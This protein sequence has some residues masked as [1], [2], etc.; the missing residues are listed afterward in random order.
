VRIK[1]RNHGE[2]RVKTATKKD[3]KFTKEWEGCKRIGEKGESYDKMDIN[4][5]LTC[6]YSSGE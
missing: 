3:A 6:R 2:C 4:R 5:A 1:G